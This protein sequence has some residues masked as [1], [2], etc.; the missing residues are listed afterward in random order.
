MVEELRNKLVELEDSRRNI[1]YAL[2]MLE[3]GVGFTECSDVKR[4]LECLIKFNNY[5][6][7]K[8]L[9]LVLMQESFD[10]PLESVIKKEL[11]SVNLG[12]VL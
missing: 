7:S 4:D 10:V 5:L 6:S 9:N 3:G 8:I 2:D 11:E 1:D 12:G